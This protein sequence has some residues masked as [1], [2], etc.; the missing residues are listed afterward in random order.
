MTDQPISRTR[1][2]YERGKAE[3]LVRKARRSEDPE[4]AE[5]LR[6][7]AEQLKQHSEAALRHEPE[8]GDIRE[9]YPR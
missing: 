1:A 4:E 6:H 2:E 7:R 8:E 5:R 9:E 3:E